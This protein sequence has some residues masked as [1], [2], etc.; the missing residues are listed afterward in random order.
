M[1]TTE[2]L[3]HLEITAKRISNNQIHLLNGDKVLFDWIADF[4]DDDQWMGVKIKGNEYDLNYYDGN[5]SIYG[6][7][8]DG[9]ST[10]TNTSDIITIKVL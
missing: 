5:I 6:L 3:K 9:T 1:S 8:I 10:S 2:D 7:T 4:D